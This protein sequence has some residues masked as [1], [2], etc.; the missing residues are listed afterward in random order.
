MRKIYAVGD[1]H[2]EF[3]MLNKAL[4]L[5]EDDGGPEASIVFLGGILTEDPTVAGS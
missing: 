5:I 2:G 3:C 1:I 4:E